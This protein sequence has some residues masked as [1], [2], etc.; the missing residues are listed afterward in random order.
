M[1]FLSASFQ[2]LE[3]FKNFNFKRVIAYMCIIILYVLKALDFIFNNKNPL[4]NTCLSKGSLDREESYK[5][6]TEKCKRNAFSQT[7]LEKGIQ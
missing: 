6:S 1:Y 2:I 4:V 5:H 7:N 3:F